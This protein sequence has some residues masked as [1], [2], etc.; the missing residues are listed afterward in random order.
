MYSIR[1]PLNQTVF[2]N[3]RHFNNASFHEMKR[4]TAREF[5]YDAKDSRLNHTE[6]TGRIPNEKTFIELQ[7]HLFI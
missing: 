2:N 1:S 4:F 5:S 6:T 3:A 7:F